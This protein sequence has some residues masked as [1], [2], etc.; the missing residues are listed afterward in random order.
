[1]DSSQKATFKD[2]TPYWR[3][4]LVAVFL[5]AALAFAISSTLPV[6]YKST[7]SILI[8]QQ[9][10]SGSNAYQELKSAEFAGKVVSEA[11]LS[12]SF[13]N[14][15]MNANTKAKDYLSQAATPEDKLKLWNDSVTIS[16]VANTGVLTLSLYFPSRDGSRNVLTSM[17]ELLQ[18]DGN[19]YYGNNRVTVKVIN[20]PYYLSDP[21]SPRIFLNTLAGA[22]LALIIIIALIQL[23]GNG[24]LYFLTNTLDRVRH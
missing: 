1:M 19:A 17:V 23:T 18:K 10:S 7:A 6:Q 16:Q 20:N 9:D 2:F 15:V 21:A 8:V 3:E 5:F 14:G 13:M 11:I 12:N 22:A 24:F 4:L